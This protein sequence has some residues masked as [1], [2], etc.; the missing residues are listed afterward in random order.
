MKDDCFI[1]TNFIKGGSKKRAEFLA[2]PEE[3][4]AQP[5]GCTCPDCGC[6]CGDC[7]ACNCAA[8]CSTSQCQTRC[9]Y[10]TQYVL[11][12][13]EFSPNQTLS[14]NNN[15]S[16]NNSN[17]YVTKSVVYAGLGTTNYGAETGTSWSNW[18]NE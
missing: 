11:H 10:D 14:S 7:V 12:A 5:E 6:P 4:L 9:D 2:E 17:G 13:V 18:W 15:S 3:A 1:V 8:Y 16:L